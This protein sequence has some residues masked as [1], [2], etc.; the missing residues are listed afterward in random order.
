[1]LIVVLVAHVEHAGTADLRRIQ[2]GLHLKSGMRG[3]IFAQATIQ[4]AALVGIHRRG[5]LEH[6]S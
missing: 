2:R 6:A 1:M 3:T 4:L 5:V